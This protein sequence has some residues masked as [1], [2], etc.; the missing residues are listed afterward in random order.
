[1]SPVWDTTL[2]LPGTQR[3]SPVKPPWHK[4]TDEREK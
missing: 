2:I 1:M 3:S 4:A